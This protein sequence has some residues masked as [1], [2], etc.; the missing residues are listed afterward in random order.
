MR[1]LLLSLFSLVFILSIA[2]GSRRRDRLS[3][4]ELRRLTEAVAERLESSDRLGPLISALKEN[5][6][7][8]S[9]LLD[10]ASGRNVS[11]RLT[12]I[13]RQL[14]KTVSVSQQKSWSLKVV[15]MLGPSLKRLAMGTQRLEAAVNNLR[16]RTGLPPL[17]AA[18]RTRSKN[19]TT[20]GSCITTARFTC[21][22]VLLKSQPFARAAKLCKVRYNGNLL[23]GNNKGDER[24]IRQKLTADK[25][26]RKS[27]V[28][29]RPRRKT[30]RGCLVVNAAG[31]YARKPCWAKMKAVCAVR[32]AAGKRK[33]M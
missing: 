15:R 18:N 3:D 19:A 7:A 24:V 8:M 20:S 9:R 27:F 10:Q 4:R 12:R 21:E 29:V 17:P 16:N 2:E 32:K 1:S 23:Q 22:Y 13:E 26:T 31:T 6:V 25:A 28:W 30:R 14:K 11:K 5:T 33:R